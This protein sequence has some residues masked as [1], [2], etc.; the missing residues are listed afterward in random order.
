M[1]E[2]FVEISAVRFVHNM[3]GADVINIK[4][5]LERCLQ[6]CSG[7]HSCLAVAYDHITGI[8][9]ELSSMVRGMLIDMN[10]M[11][12]DHYSTIFLKYNSK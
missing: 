3:R 4:A 10:W 8:C 12:T 2:N 11:Y 6:Q 1:R 7:E 9:S 5:S